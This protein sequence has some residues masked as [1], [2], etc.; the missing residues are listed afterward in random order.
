MQQQAKHVR[1]DL[2]CF[3]LCRIRIKLIIQSIID[4]CL[5]ARYNTVMDDREYI[6]ISGIQKLT[7]LDYPEHMACTLFVPGCNFKCPYC[8]NSELLGAGVQHYDES[9]IFDFLQSRKGKLEGVCVTGG[10]P[11]LYNDLG[12]FLAKIKDLGYL[13]K[14]DTNGYRPQVLSGVIND[15]LV[16]YVAMDIKSSLDRYPETIGLLCGFKPDNIIRSAELL[17]RGN[18]DYEFR[19]TVANE[20]VDAAAVEDIAKMIIGAKRYFLQYFVMRETVPDASLTPPTKEQMN[21]YLSVA[22]EYVPAT[23]I[24]GDI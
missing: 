19:T 17:M 8:H 16:D 14:L 2:K 23:E 18:V 22:R 11:T 20:F 1:S 15:G 3:E 12:R 13:V 10:E 4:F 7:L 24:R 6:K 5:T 21:Y 9:E